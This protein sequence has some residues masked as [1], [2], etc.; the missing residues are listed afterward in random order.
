MQGVLDPIR[1]EGGPNLCSLGPLGKL[2][3]HALR[4]RRGLPGMLVS[5]N[6]GRQPA[7]HD[8]LPAVFWRFV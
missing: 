2:R 1:R 7:P 8:G 4:C 6:G 3:R 5:G